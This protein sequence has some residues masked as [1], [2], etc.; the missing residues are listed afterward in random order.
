MPED[1]MAPLTRRSL[2]AATTLALGASALP[3]QSPAAAKP[4]GKQAPALYRYRVGSYELTAIG[5]GVWDRPIDEN[6]VINAGAGVVRKAMTDA[7]MPTTDSLPIPF[8]TLL[9]NTGTKLILIDTGTGGQITATAGTFGANLAAAGISPKSIDIILI[10]HFHPDHI[11]GIKTKDDERV[12]PNAEIKVPAA[13]WNYW[14]DDGNLSR[15][16]DSTRTYFLNSRRIF[17][18]IAKDVGRFE[19]DQELAPGV[20]SIAAPGHTPGHMAFAVASENQSMLVLSDTA[21]HPKLF[22]RHP[23]WQPVLDMDGPLA[24]ETRKRLLDRAVSDKM[25]VQ[26]YHFPFPASGHVAKERRSFELVPVEW[27]PI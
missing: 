5:D 23:E 16:P 4:S 25:L 12:F 9:V 7:F 18:N 17:K 24:V 14:M 11:N 10:S 13:E 22:L 21:N 19:P 15:A 20:T 27:R 2:L 8:T 3:K 1:D 26:G 6:F